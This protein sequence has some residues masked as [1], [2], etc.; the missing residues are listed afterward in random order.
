MSG[1]NSSQEDLIRALPCWHGLSAIEP[2]HG[3]LSNV[4]Y[5]VSDN[6]GRYVVRLG[7]DYPFHHVDRMREIMTARAAH[8]AG[9][10]PQVLY[11]AP[12]VAVSA[13]IDGKTFDASDV[14]ANANRIAPFLAKFHRDLALH[15]SG[16]GFMFW[17]FHVIRDY[18]RLLSMEDGAWNGKLE[19]YVDLAN[20]L[21]AVQ[22]PLPI[23]FGHND[24]LPANFIDDGTR[25]WLIDFEYAGFSTAMFDIAGVAVNADMSEAQSEEFL[26]A[27]FASKTR[28]VSSQS[29]KSG[30][31]LRSFSAMQCAATLREALWAMVSQVH[32]KTPGVDFNAYANENLARLTRALNNYRKAYP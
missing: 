26:A 6:S 19:G 8:Q 15:V 4:S 11:S 20:E 22:V 10:A 25:L 32:L 21:E 5:L 16:A 12:G 27:Y 30:D 14:R 29:I 13:F 2:V 24:L 9:F 3:G 1:P 7:R 18:A 31:L 17:V 28:S 23:V